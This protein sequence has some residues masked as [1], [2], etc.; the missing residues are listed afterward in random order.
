MAHR[1]PYHWGLFYL[2]NQVAWDRIVLIGHS[3]GAGHV[4]YLAKLHPCKGVIYFAGPQDS[5]QLGSAPW[6][7]KP[8]KTAESH[9][10]FLFHEQDFF[11]VQWQ[12]QAAAALLGQTGITEMK[13]QNEI[14]DPKNA[15][16]FISQLPVGDAHNELLTL[17]F[18]KVWASLLGA[19]WTF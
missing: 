3:Q 8:G 9:Q 17:S 7:S 4:G 10:L 13:I 15:N 5:F 16:V 6:L 1:D 19:A 14:H 11:G 18:A 2:N 12:L